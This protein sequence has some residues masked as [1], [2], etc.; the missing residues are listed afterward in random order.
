MMCVMIPLF[1]CICMFGT[2]ANG[3]ADGEF[4]IAITICTFGI[5]WLISR[6]GFSIFFWNILTM[7]SSERAKIEANKED[8]KY[9][10]TL[11]VCSDIY[12][13]VDSDR[14]VV[15]MRKA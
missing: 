6:V 8:L 1:A 7:T 10:E 13:N 3:R 15:D 11:K 5:G 4:L 12:S 2:T 14:V 9:L